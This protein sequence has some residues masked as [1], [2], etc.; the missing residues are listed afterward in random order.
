MQL[1]T[2]WRGRLSDKDEAIVE[3]ALAATDARSLAERDVSDLS[4]GERQRAMLARA[5]AQSPQ[6][7]VLDETLAFLDLPRRV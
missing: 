5:L 2:G 7:L 3:D 6:V 1:H 4:D